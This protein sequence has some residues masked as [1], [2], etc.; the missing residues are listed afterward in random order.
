MNKNYLCGFPLYEFT[1]P[2][3]V[4]DRVFESVKNL[5]YTQNAYNLA[6]DLSQNNFFYDRE[7]FDFFDQ[8]LEEVRKIYYNDKIRL[9]VTGCWAN[10]T[11]KLSK[12]HKHIHVNSILSGI[13]YLTSHSS[14]HTVFGMPDPYMRFQQEGLLTLSKRGNEAHITAAEELKSKVLPERGKLV[15]FPSQVS[16]EVT[17]NLDK[18]PRYTIAFNTFVSGQLSINHGTTYLHVNTV[19]VKETLDTFNK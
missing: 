7:L 16:H 6:S 15:I 10:K 14:G 1:C 12:H 11:T 17:A 13:L 3:S 19:G 2:E 5:D 8:S 4:I 18:D 9:T